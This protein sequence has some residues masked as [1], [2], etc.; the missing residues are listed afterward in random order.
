VVPFGAFVDIAP[1]KSGL[2]HVSEY[3]VAPTADMS[4][5]CVVSTSRVCV[6][7][8]RSRGCV[9]GLWAVRVVD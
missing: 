2:V 3:D 8:G 6:G 5:V 9:C 1:G 4:K 7:G